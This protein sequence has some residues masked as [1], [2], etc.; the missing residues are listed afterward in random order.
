[1]RPFRPGQASRWRAQVGAG[2]GPGRGSYSQNS[3]GIGSGGG[4]GGL[5][6]AGLTN[7]P[8]GTSY[9]SLLQPADLGSGGGTY[10]PGNGVPGSV[11]GGALQLKVAGSLVLNGRVSADGGGAVYEGLGGGSGG[12]LWLSAGTLSGNGVIS[13]DGG[14]DDLLQG[15]GGGGGRIAVYFGANRFTGSLS[16]HGGEGANAGAAG[17]IYTRATAAPSGDL[18]VD[19]AGLSG[20]DTPLSTPET[21]NL[22]VSGGA[23]AYPLPSAPALLVSNLLVDSGG[24][25]TCLIGQSNLDLTV[26]GSAIVGSNGWLSVDGKGYSGTNGGPGAGLMTGNYAGSGAGYG[27]AG[28]ASLRGTPGGATYGSAQQPVDWGSRGGVNPSYTNFCQGGGAI[29][30]RVGGPLTVNGRLTANGNAAL[31]E[32]AGGGAG[33]S[34]WV[35]ASQFNGSGL[36]AAKGGSGDPNEGGGGGGG[37]I[38]LYCRT[39]SFA[40]VIA[41]LGGPGAFPGVNGTVFLGSFVAS[42]TVL[43]QSPMVTPAALALSAQVQGPNLL[44]AWQGTAGATHRLLWSSNLVD[45]LPCGPPLVGTNGPMSLTVPV[46]TEPGKFFRFS[47]SQ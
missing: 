47:T 4:Y 20:A 8:G 35:T 18:A 22:T 14:P 3:G 28:G 29:R 23:V 41:V 7:S 1:M 9:G 21:F 6:G 24:A 5:G 44:L 12:S 27:G 13:A 11:G 39:N 36:I 30:L 34:I 33:G 25:L 10:L 26:L 32:G 43:A 15:G 19:N 17:T 45:W 37:R 31:F 38:A 42:R 40:G 2:Q 16:A 46:G